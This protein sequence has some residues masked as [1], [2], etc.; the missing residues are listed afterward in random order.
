MHSMFIIT[1]RCANFLWSYY[2]CN[3]K[4]ALLSSIDKPIHQDL[5][6]T[7]TKFS[8][9]NL[10]FTQYRQNY[11]HATVSMLVKP[12]TQYHKHCASASRYTALVDCVCWIPQDIARTPVY[13]FGC[14]LHKI[15]GYIPGSLTFRQIHTTSM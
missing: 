12:Q 5:F 2:S 1:T 13:F 11:T 14:A 4:S 7:H 6:T 8:A 3:F 15:W 10:D 9:S